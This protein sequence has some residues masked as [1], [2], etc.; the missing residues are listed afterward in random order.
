MPAN[1]PNSVIETILGLV[2]RNH[3]SAKISGDIDSDDLAEG[4]VR[5]FF[6]S[7]VK[8]GT[9]DIMKEFRENP[10]QPTP[11]PTMWWLETQKTGVENQIERK[12]ALHEMDITT[13]NFMIKSK[14]KPQLDVYASEAY[15]AVQTIAHQDKTINAEFCPMWKVFADR[16]SSVMKDNVQIFTG[17]SNEGFAELLTKNIGVEV[18]KAKRKLE[19]DMT[20][21]DK[22]QARVALLFEIKIMKLFG[23][24]Q[25]YIDTWYY[26][27]EVT[28]LRSRQHKL[29][30][31]VLF[32]RKS[33]DAATFFG[34]TLFLMGVLSVVY[35]MEEMSAMLF[36]G[37]DSVLIGD[38]NIDFNYSEEIANYFNLEAKFLRDY[39]RI[40]FCSKFI[41]V[42]DNTVEFVPD[43]M[44]MLTKLGRCD[45]VNPTHVECYRESLIDLTTPYGNGN[46][47]EL[48]AGN[49]SI[50]C[51]TQRRGTS[52]VKMCLYHLWIET[53]FVKGLKYIEIE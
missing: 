27:H 5:G 6:E 29:S 25:E 34:N 39:S 12:L 44:K 18:L 53:V 20:K 1:R 3:A 46:T 24:P 23:F 52:C 19:I 4:M 33:G 21:F 17:V 16:V 35:E 28:T 10:I 36:S 48:V 43:P 2:K 7:Y 40:G 30:S 14:V 38:G 45:L 50:R 42:N 47:V 9:E 49:Y 37:D 26:M 41:V 8:P 51:I 31:Q 11:G 15:S 32:Q 22:S 13:Y